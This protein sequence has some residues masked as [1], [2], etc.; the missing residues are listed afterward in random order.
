[1]RVSARNRNRERR[2]AFS[3]LAVSQIGGRITFL[4]WLYVVIGGAIALWCFHRSEL[5]RD[6]G[7][8]LER[9]LSM[10]NAQVG[11]SRDLAGMI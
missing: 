3:S 4:Y 1:M 10:G 6:G 9:W 11:M 7:A 5:I 2:T 8:A